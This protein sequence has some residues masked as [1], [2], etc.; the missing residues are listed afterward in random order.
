MTTLHN[1]TLDSNKTI[2]TKADRIRVRYEVGDYV[3]FPVANNE[4][5]LG[6]IEKFNPKKALVDVDNLIWSV[7]YELLD[8]W[9]DD[10]QFKK[11]QRLLDVSV[12]ARK[13]M[14]M[15]GLDDW[16]FRFSATRRKIGDCNE[17]Q[18]TIRIG[19]IHAVR[20]HPSQVT[21]TILHEIAHAL[22]GSKARHGP[23]WKKIAKQIGATPRS[24]MRV[25]DDED[26]MRALQEA[27][28][29]FSVGM[30]VTFRAN[31]GITH[32]GYIQKINP[33]RA[34][35]SCGVHVFSVPYT[36]LQP[37]EE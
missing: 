5:M 31:G 2:V 18:K 22:A 16:T 37:L 26:A 8:D 1:T 20:D 21:D 33:K 14:N 36:L 28:A 24:R 34:K 13:L 10:A 30:E 4:R 19:R 6:K 15:H 3:S 23:K 32:V 29:K 7:P 9:I 25:E 12:E 11:E 27:K 17:R 35:I